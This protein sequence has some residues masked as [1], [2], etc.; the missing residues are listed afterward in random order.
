MSVSLKG[1]VSFPLGPVG[2]GIHHAIV[3]VGLSCIQFVEK[4][5]PFHTVAWRESIAD[6]VAEDIAPVPDSLMLIQNGHFVPQTPRNILYAYYG[7][8][9]ATRARFISPSF[10]QITTPWIRPINLAIV[11]LDEPNMAD[12]SM[13]PLVLRALEEV[14]LEG[15][16]TTGGA[17]VVVGVAG[18]AQGPIGVAPQGDIFSMR[19]TGATTLTAGAWSLAT[20]TWQDTLPAGTYVCLGLEFIG[21]TALAARLIFEE[22]WDRPGCLGQ[23][24]VSGNGPQLFR[25]GRLGIW[26][27]FNANRMPNIECL[28]NAA[29]TAQEFYLDLMKVA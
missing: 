24:L 28:A 8:A 20:V 1:G 16:Q 29:D 10:R 21:A 27:R 13:N 11:P 7:A 6:I 9:G 14:Q 2:I 22:Q 25:K 4:Y 15:Y 17:A 3:V 5:M 19:G 12:Y 26:G 23:S 18:L